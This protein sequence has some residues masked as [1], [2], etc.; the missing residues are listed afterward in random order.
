LADGIVAF[1]T[2]A[3]LLYTITNF[4]KQ[5]KLMIFMDYTKRY[6][7]ILINSPLTIYDSEFCTDKLD[8]HEEEQIHVT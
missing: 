7:D 8:V 6:Q 4:N 2:V 5:Q 3:G 1:I